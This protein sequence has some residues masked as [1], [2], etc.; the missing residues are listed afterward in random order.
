[1]KDF[2]YAL[3]LDELKNAKYTLT[4]DANGW[5]LLMNG[6]RVEGVDFFN[7][8]GCAYIQYGNWVVGKFADYGMRDVSKM[9][10]AVWT[11][12]EIDEATG[13]KTITA[14]RFN[15]EIVVTKLDKEG[16]LVK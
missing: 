3:T 1:M 13:I 12:T 8:R 10:K 2:N 16:K 9:D 15:G 6:K 7:D 11:E 4:Y 5:Y 14:K